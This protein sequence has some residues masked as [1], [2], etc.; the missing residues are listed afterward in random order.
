MEAFKKVQN[1]D[2][3][4][5]VSLAQETEVHDFL[6]RHDLG[7][8]FLKKNASDFLLWKETLDRCKD[9]PGLSSCSQ[10]LPGKRKMLEIDEEG[11][12]IQNFVSCAYQAAIDEKRKHQKKF[13]LSHM[14][15]KEYEIDLSILAKGQAKEYQ[16]AFRTILASIQDAQGVYLYG[17][18]GVGKTYLMLGLC[19]LYAKENKSIC[20]VKLPQLI[21]DFKQKLTDNEYRLKNMS[22]LQK[23][24]IVVLDDMGA[25]AI[26]AWTRDEIVLPVLE[27]RMTHQKKTYFTSNYAPE[28]LFNQYIIRNESN[29]KISAL[30]LL[31]RIRSLAKPCKLSG[32]SRR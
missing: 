8:D 6:K 30:R 19:N 15:S 3:E 32:E 9:C 4:W 12:L 7:M 23:A 21:S 20:F 10:P 5:I 1:M 28:E 22:L 17:Q 13:W 25:E 26:S 11:F 27:Y 14:S 18:P 31:E 24:D 2:L 29:S 16:L